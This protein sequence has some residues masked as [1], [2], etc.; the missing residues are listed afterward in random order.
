MPLLHDIRESL[1]YQEALAEGIELGKK[2]AIERQ[3]AQVME[4]E[5][6]RLIAKLATKR[7]SAT[8]ISELLDL[9]F[10]R[11]RRVLG[12]ATNI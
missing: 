4:E 10:E 9:D 12:A 6:D 7:L 3:K 11:V 5:T 2:E 1:V 8:E